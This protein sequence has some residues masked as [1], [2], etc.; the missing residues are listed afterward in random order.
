MKGTGK[1]EKDLVTVCTD[2]KKVIFLM[3]NGWMTKCM[4]KGFLPT[5]MGEL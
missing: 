3:E 4:G 1:R 2:G 5:M